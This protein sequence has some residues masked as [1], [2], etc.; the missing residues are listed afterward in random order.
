MKR[1]YQGPQGGFRLTKLLKPLLNYGIRK[2][3]KTG[4]DTSQRTFKAPKR[5][6]PANNAIT[7]QQ[8]IR[9]IYS[10]G[11]RKSNKKALRFKKR[12]QSAINGKAPM[13]TYV[14][15]MDNLITITSPGTAWS[16]APYQM[17]SGAANATT[18]EEP[19]FSLGESS[20]NSLGVARTTGLSVY[21]RNFF[22][23]LQ[24]RWNTTDV[25]PPSATNNPSMAII[26]H[27][28]LNYALQNI[29]GVAINVDIYEFVPA[30]NMTPAD[31]FFPPENAWNELINQEANKFATGITTP[32]TPSNLVYGVTPFEAPGFGK[33]WKIT[34]KTRILLNAGATTAFQ[35][36]N[37]GYLWR[38]QLCN[39]YSAIKG[40]T[41]CVVFVVASEIGFGIPAITGVLN[42]AVSKQV[43]FKFPNTVNNL[44]NGLSAVFAEKY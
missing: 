21:L 18:S 32:A 35:V 12:V 11:K 24:T 33:H 14:A 10:K 43:H 4:R 40:Q 8:D 44:S 6:N 13:Q 9:S 37:K 39:Q 28:E 7:T 41:K 2:S 17:I 20:W 22:S 42:I 29:S 19:G 36:K 31:L 5:N 16:T 38:E 25:G 30:R 27:Q 1:K 23:K 15:Y 34:A 3:L 26:K